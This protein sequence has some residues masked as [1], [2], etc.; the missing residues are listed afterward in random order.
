MFVPE[1]IVQGWPHGPN[2]CNTAGVFVELQE[3]RAS[4]ET[5]GSLLASKAGSTAGKHAK[6]V[7]VVTDDDED[8]VILLTCL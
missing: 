2:K 1:S 6:I 7:D 5:A 4:L 8:I 3:Y